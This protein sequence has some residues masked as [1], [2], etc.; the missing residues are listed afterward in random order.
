MPPL[1]LFRAD[2]SPVIGGGHV[3]RCLSFADWLADVGWQCAFAFREP[4]LAT[5]PALARSAHQLLPLEGPVDGEVPELAR[6]Y[7]S[8]CDLM[9]IDHYGRSQSFQ[10]QCREIAKRI[11]AFEDW[12]NRVHD[13]DFLLDA[14]VG[15]RTCEYTNL[16][17]SSCQ[18]LLGSQHAILHPR[19]AATRPAAL[20]RRRATAAPTR[21]LIS[22]GMTDP[23]NMTA[24]ALDGVVQS[25][26][27]LDVDIVLGSAAPSLSSIRNRAVA[28][29]ARMHI[30]V[31]DM[32]ELMSSADIAIGGAG[33]SSFERCCLGL[34]TL[35]MPTVDNQR[36]SA[37]ALGEL[38]AIQVIESDGSVA[39]SQ[40]ADA[41]IRLYQDAASRTEMA[42]AAAEV[43][44]GR[45]ALRV[46]TAITGTVAASN[47]KEV[48][49]RLAE[50]SDC[51]TL[52]DWQQHPQ[53]RRFA[54]NPK[55]P[56][57]AEHARWFAQ[58]MIDPAR[59]LLIVMCGVE[60]AGMLRLDRLADGSRK[61]SI[62]T[63]P[64]HYRHGIASAALEL[65][66]RFIPAG[67]LHA[68]ILAGNIPSHALFRRAG[69]RERGPALY[70]HAAE[71]R[72]IKSRQ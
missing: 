40:V 53:S 49:L 3:Q 34:P 59:L 61:V 9:V 43:C 33:V 29:G 30:D 13:A 47:G 60:P 1:C 18:Q 6:R 14:T 45:G 65:A 22:I 51:D 63:A 31:A 36:D 46:L 16:V 17:S 4:T 39:S 41:V 44:D 71:A 68:E 20:A 7:D 52:F 55:A 42:A 58:T 27:P 5:V 38:G 66:R 2:A 54:H 69:Y 57:A 15:R 37:D 11:L 35:V 8:V 67:E 48:R 26:L 19:F 10:T 21:L 12:P 24:I 70:V 28:A 50:Y 32:A 25:R 72:A 56:T 62:L 64:S 23:V